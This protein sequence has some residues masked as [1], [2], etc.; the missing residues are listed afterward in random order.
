MNP[1]RR[2]GPHLQFAG[3]QPEPERE[4]RWERFKTAYIRRLQRKIARGWIEHRPETTRLCLRF[5]RLAE[6]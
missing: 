2:K 1:A 4:A 5:L 6:S 3:A